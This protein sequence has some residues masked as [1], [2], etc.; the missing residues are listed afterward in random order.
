MR[1]YSRDPTVGGN[2]VVEGVLEDEVLDYLDV[3]PDNIRIHVYACIDI[4]LSCCTNDTGFEFQLC[5]KDHVDGGTLTTP[6][7][8]GDRMHPALRDV[9]P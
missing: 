5:E 2:P 8:L 3:L 1:S 7:P 9:W 6:G 4:A